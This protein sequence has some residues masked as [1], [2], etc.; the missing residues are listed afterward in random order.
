MVKSVRRNVSSE[1][2]AFF[3]PQNTSRIFYLLALVPLI[4]MAS[5]YFQY[6]LGLMI[7][8][9]AYIILLLKKNKLFSHPKAGIFQ[10]VFGLTV[11]IIS[12]FAYFIVSPFF[13]QAALYG[14]ANYFLYTVGLFLVFF[15][16]R[17]L[18]E[19]FSP[20]FLVVAFLTS[21]IASD[22]AKS[23]FS[24]FIPQL[25]SFTASILS[26]LGIAVTY[27]ALAPNVIVLNTTSGSI[28]LMI[29]W[30][31]VGFATVYIFSI[32]LVVII[33]EEP[34]ST[35]TKVIWSTIGVLGAFSIAMIRLTAIFAGFYFFGSKCGQMIH[36]YAGYVLLIIW[37]IIFLY[38]FS[39]RNIILQ[40]MR[41][42]SARTP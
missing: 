26:F 13:P 38:A 29:D 21:S 39:K 3:S 41:R 23:V 17:A 35:K 1:I 2:V 19:A 31:C 15:Q 12:F 42:T 24:P 10:K 16:I 14:F 6:P 20:L 36:R 25:A 4:L 32:I 40:K 37:T 7:P 11:V 9:Y 8:I 34:S 22:L 28:P 33:A 30:A 5:S 27:S 18:K